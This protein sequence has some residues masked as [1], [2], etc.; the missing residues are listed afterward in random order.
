MTTMLQGPACI[1]RSRTYRYSPMTDHACRPRAFQAPSLPAD[2][3][4]RLAQ[5]AVWAK[6]LGHPVRLRILRFLLAQEGCMCGDIVE[7]IHLA[8]ATISQHLKMLKEAGLIQ[9]TID[10]SKICYC[11]NPLVLKALAAGIT[12]LHANRHATTDPSCD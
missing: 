6:A 2:D 1:S 11:V 7:H 8:Q 4:D 9:G 12:G 3:Q 5:L 10:G